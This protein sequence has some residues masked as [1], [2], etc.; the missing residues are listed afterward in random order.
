MDW[1]CILY[2]VKCLEAFYPESLGT[3]YIHNAPW[4]FKGIWMVLGPLLDPVV[5]SKVVF[6]SKATDI[7]GH[8]PPSR[9]IADL[10]GNVTTGFEFTE[11]QDGENDLLKNEGERKKRFDQCVCRLTMCHA[12]TD[13]VRTRSFMELADEFE[14]VTRKWSKGGSA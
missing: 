13:A 12:E 9:L 2:I 8:I 11:P 5:R 4:I 1:N 6:S 7:E 14:E 3:L 10:G